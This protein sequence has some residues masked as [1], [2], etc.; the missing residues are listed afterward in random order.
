MTVMLSVNLGP[1]EFNC[2]FSYPDYT[3]EPNEGLPF[4][5]TGRLYVAS[6]RSIIQYHS[7]F[8]AQPNNDRESILDEVIQFKNGLGKNVD[9]S[10]R[11][12][13]ASN[14]MLAE[15]S[16]A[17]AVLES[18]HDQDTFIEIS[19]SH[20]TVM[21]FERGYIRD[22]FNQPSRKD[23]VRP[24]GYYRMMHVNLPKWPFRFN[25]ILI[26]AAAI[27][28]AS[29]DCLVFMAE[30]GGGKTTS[31][32]LAKKAQL[33]VLGDEQI[34]LEKQGSDTVAWAT[35]F[36]CITDGLDSARVKAF[37]LLKQG[38]HFELAR[39]RPS[40]ALRKIWQDRV[41]AQLWRE[42]LS[43]RQR[44]KTFHLLWDFLGSVPVYEMT[45]CKDYIDWDA[46]NAITE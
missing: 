31:A 36:N 37:L 28:S 16:V 45:F 44:E 7:Q 43:A 42:A 5:T 12:S 21:N 17:D 35:Q 29:G 9:I 4:I 22:F 19:S 26:H 25:A 13:V 38:T 10:L 33:Q 14:S 39:R 20:V 11:G 30:S 27:K 32:Q 23:R 1:F 2:T 18:L 15:I 40:E 46:L 3:I 34:L 8:I 24:Y 6:P 41:N